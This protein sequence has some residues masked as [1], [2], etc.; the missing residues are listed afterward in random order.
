MINTKEKQKRKEKEKEINNATKRK[1]TTQKK[2][3]K[4]NKK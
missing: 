4:Q 2:E 3:H 1:I